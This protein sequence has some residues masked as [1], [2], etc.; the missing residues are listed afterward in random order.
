[1]GAV[2]LGRRSRIFSNRSSGTFILRPTILSA[3]SAPCRSM[4]I[5]SIFS[6][7]QGSVMACRPAIN[8]VFDCINSW[9]I[10]SPCARMVVSVSVTSTMASARP[11][12]ALASVAPQEKEI[13]TFIP[14]SSKN[15]RVTLTS[16]VDILLP[17][18]S[19]ILVI[20]ES[21]GTAITHLV[22]FLL[23]FE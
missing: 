12:T 17:S 9:I 13:S 5:W 22:E 1:V 21:P 18:S 16:S 19:S 14:R 2:T 6:F 7:F 10:R 15:L 3:R 11:D 8:W 23:T 4:A 20:S